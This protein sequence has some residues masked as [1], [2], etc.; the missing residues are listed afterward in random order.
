MCGVKID[1]GIELK[2]WNYVG[3][4]KRGMPF[5]QWGFLHVGTIKNHIQLKEINIHTI[6]ML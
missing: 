2:T 4:R 6:G 1:W 5:L 3:I